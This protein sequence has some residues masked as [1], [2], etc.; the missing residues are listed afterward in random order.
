MIN[1]PLA[2][3]VGKQW[4]D[5]LGGYHS[6]NFYLILGVI[7]LHI[8]AVVAYGVFKG[9][10]LVRPMITGKKRLPGAM[11]AP[12]LASPLRAILVGLVAAVIAVAVANLPQ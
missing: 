5:R 11:R 9:Q 10:D 12:R 1:G 4:S 7:V 2:S 3:Y 6:L 8:L